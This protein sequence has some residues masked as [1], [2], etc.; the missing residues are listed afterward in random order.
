MKNAINFL[1]HAMKNETVACNVISMRYREQEKTTIRPLQDQY[2]TPI[3]K[4]K[5]LAALFA[6]LFVVGVGSVWGGTSTLTSAIISTGTVASGYNNY[7]FTADSKTWNA[8]AIHNYHSNAT[9]T[10]Y[11]LQIKKYASSTA[12]YVQIPTMPGDITSITMTVSSTNQP[13]TGGGNTATLYFSN[14]NTTSEAGTDIASGT[15]ASSVTIDCSALSLTSGYIT[16]GGAVRI[17]DVEVTYTTGGACTK[18]INITAGTPSNGTFT[19]SKSGTQAT[20]N[21]AVTVI[22]TPTANTG[23]F[24]SAVTAPNSSSIVNNGDGT[25]TVTYA[26]NTNAD[27]EINVT[28]TARTSRTVTFKN[29]GSTVSST[30]V[31]DGDAVGTLPTLTS[32]AACDPTST[33]FMGW[34]EST[35]STKTSTEPTYISAET[36]VSG[37]DKVYNAVWAKAS[38]GGSTEVFSDALTVSGTS[39]VTTRTGWD[40]L[41]KVYGN[42][43]TSVRVSSGSYNGYL[44]TDELDLSSGDA[45]IS[46]QLKAYSTTESAQ[47]TI[48][49]TNGTLSQSVFEESDNTKFTTYSATLTGGD[50]ATQITF[51]GNKNK[52]AYL[53]SVSITCGS[54]TYSDYLTSCGP[55]I[56]AASDYYVTS[57][58]DQKVKVVIPV[59]ATNFTSNSTLSASISGTGFSLYGWSNKTITKNVDLETEVVVQYQPG[60]FGST[61]NAT[62]TLSASGASNKTVTIHGRSLPEQFAIV[63]NSSGD[64]AM[65]ANMAGTSDSRKAEAVTIESNQVKCAS[66]TYVYTLEGV[67]TD[68]YATHGSAV[69]L[70]GYYTNGYLQTAGS[71]SNEFN[72][73]TYSDDDTFEWI[74]I[75]TDNETYNIQSHNSTVADETRLIRYRNTGHFGNFTSTTGGQ[76]SIK[77]YEVAAAC[78]PTNI[79]TN[80]ITHNSAVITFDGTAASHTLTITGTGYS[81]TY[82][83][84]ATYTSGTTISGLSP[85]TTYTF[86]LTPSCSNY[87][88]V[89]GEFTTTTAPITIMLSRDGVTETLTDVTNPYKLP[90]SPDRCEEWSFAGWSASE[91]DEGD[92]PTL[93]TQATANGTYYAV[94]QKSGGGAVTYTKVTSD[95]SLSA[96]NKY[97]I[98]WYDDD[99]DEM[100]VAGEITSSDIMADVTDNTATSSSITALSSSAE[101]FTLGGSSGAWTFTSKNGTLGATAVKKM[102]YDDGTQTWT[103]SI[104]SGDATITNGTSSYG[105]LYFN[106]ASP[107]FTTYT[108]SAQKLPSLFVASGGTTY[109]TTTDCV[110]CTSAGA[111]FTLGTNVTKNTESANFTNTISYTKTNTKTQAWTSSNTSVA[112]VNA[113]TGEV[114]IVGQGTATITVKQSIDNTNPSDIV[115]AVNMSYTLTVNPPSVDV[116]EVTADDKIIIEH[117]IDGNSKVIMEELNTGV[118]G[119]VANDI[120]FSKYF[121]AASNMKLFALYNGTQHNIDLSELRVRSCGGN[122]SSS[123]SWGTLGGLNYVELG[124]VTKLKTEYPNCL[125][126][127]F[128]EIIFWSNNKGDKTTAIANNTALRNC[129]SMEINGT[130]YDY[131]DLEGDNVPNWYCLGDKDTYDVA[132]SDGNKQ[133]VFNGDDALVLERKDG[134]TWKVID[135]FGA[136]KS[137]TDGVVGDPSNVV[138]STQNAKPTASEWDSGNGNGK[139]KV[140]TKDSDP[141]Y[142]LHETEEYTIDGNDDTPLNDNPGGYWAM[143]DWNSTTEIPLSTNRYY[144]TRNTNVKDGTNAVESNI[145]RFATLITE[146]TGE[147]VGG[148][149]NAN[150]YSGEMFSEV[151]QYDYA[152]EFKKWESVDLDEEDFQNLGNGTYSVKV[153]NLADYSCKNLRIAVV[154]KTTPTDTLA[155]VEYRVPIIVKSSGTLTNNE[156]FTTFADCS[157]CDVVILNNAT[158]AP[159]ADGRNTV[160]NVEVYAGAKLNIPSDKSLN[161][162]NLILR[163]LGD[164]IPKADIQGTLNCV[165][166][167]LYFDKRVDESQFYWITMPYNCN[168]ADVRLRNGDVPT[169]GNGKD[170]VLYTYNGVKRAN[171]QAGGCWDEVPENS[172]LVAGK[173][174]ILGVTPKTGHDFV[175]LR[176]PM[177]ATAWDKDR[178][179]IGV[180]VKGTKGTSDGVAVNHIGWNLVGNPYLTD[181]AP[182]HIGETTAGTTSSN[183][184]PE[185]LLVEGNPFTYSGTVRYVNIPQG[186]GYSEYSQIAIG[187]QVLP[188]FMSYF[189]QI[190]GTDGETYEVKFSNTLDQYEPSPVRRRMPAAEDDHI[191]WVP[192]N[193]TN[194]N[195]ETDETTLLVSNRFTDG[196]DMMDDLVKWRGDYY[197]YSV[198]TTKPVLA[199]RNATEELAFNALPDNSAAVTGVPVNF[200]AA[201]DGEYTFSINGKYGLDEVKEA[202]LWDATTQQYYD[203]LAEDYSFTSSRGENNERFTLFVRVERKEEPEI[204]TGNDNIFADGKLGLMAIDQTLVLSGLTNDADVYVYDISGKLMISDHVSG[205]SIW[206]TNVPATGVYF[207]RVNGAN[208][209]QTLRTIVK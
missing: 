23:F 168:M 111:T 141:P 137:V 142:T 16:A 118:T 76:A 191:V 176:F 185:G 33:T 91:V 148:D 161:V 119:N 70:K 35:I 112:N 8:Y 32:S 190:N 138:Y 110:D 95:A 183:I 64:F 160:N 151:G 204:A 206:R 9:N 20:C 201:Y 149:D 5:K 163:S 113:S 209:Q 66:R 103:I 120:F 19:L 49:A 34:T 89:N 135:I 131:D 192:F 11:F 1:I 81:G 194:S 196:Y 79:K 43:G 155:R 109:S 124:S 74:L 172:T 54:V 83:S 207:V 182:G 166:S 53:K 46:F 29:N 85:E 123:R 125:L 31:Y 132:D 128:T 157:T 10:V 117:D 136:V 145:G 144:L 175:E 127:P 55:A 199:T 73:T 180:P 107:R 133:F 139:I 187:S 41:S 193:L 130:T 65:A 189:V 126:P 143:A 2:K 116:V 99:E 169:Y 102:A 13:K 181:Y 87:C 60:S 67:T 167:K 150:C 51:T 188:P 96:G 44:T 45:T 50:D 205:N 129:I 7:S 164:N 25:W 171:T 114:T 39:E 86:V 105:T 147:P 28:F 146:W 92:S 36:I 80:S 77:F 57:T 197:Q 30:T 59:S 21:A 154:D 106:S 100:H 179:T 97:V 37:G 52:R 71:G 58:Q 17:W 152:T 78:K 68:R 184:I 98:G 198:I 104:S 174:Y 38:S 18:K 48:S 170:W 26:Q 195:G 24:A 22:V 40:E 101:V 202:Q 200:F 159:H 72:N 6:L 42:N 27:S 61:G 115:C 75:T 156:I 94:Y 15:G 122:G 14:D 153:D 63:A 158:L 140:V 12:Y 88:A 108:S 121:E 186:G 93:I 203:L 208:G 90:T 69:R 84:G 47:I 82:A 3:D 173:G 177:T 56:N 162:N 4:L 178:A 62:L 134:S 165:T